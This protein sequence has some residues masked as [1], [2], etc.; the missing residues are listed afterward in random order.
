V[1]ASPMAAIRNAVASILEADPELMVAYVFSEDM[2]VSGKTVCYPYVASMAYDTSDEARRGTGMGTAEVDIFCNAVCNQDPAKNGIKT[3]AAA[4]IVSRI[5]YR[6]ETYDVNELEVSNDGR[7]NTHI[8]A[9]AVDGN[10]G[11]F[12][13]GSGK[14]RIGVSVTVVFGQTYSL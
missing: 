2:F 8:L 11:D 10:V 7:Y 3:E 1:S 13:D 9:I 12:D 6:L 4:D 14:I 5:K